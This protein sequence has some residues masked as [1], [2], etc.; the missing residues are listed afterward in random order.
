MVDVYVVKIKENTG[1]DT[2]KNLAE[3]LPCAAKNRIL[4]AKDK[5][6]QTERAYAYSLL[7]FVLNG[8][9]ITDEA[10]AAEFCFDGAGKPFLKDSKIKFSVSHTDGAAA[11]AVCECG[12]IGVD[13]EKIDSEKKEKLEKI[14]ARFCRE[15]FSV[16]YNGEKCVKYLA[17]L[18][19]KTT[20]KLETDLEPLTDNDVAFL[21]WTVLESA[22][23]QEGS[24]F[25]CV[26]NAEELMGALDIES[27][28]ISIGGKRYAVS[29]AVKR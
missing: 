2:V 16:K 25:G 18:D 26:K 5:K 23:K 3:A 7:R 19:K 21:R 6:T 12:K 13:I 8:C 15:P 10:L 22:L 24:G 20:D 9:G 14:I 1:E 11:V 17:D 27:S 4:S 28:V 29:V